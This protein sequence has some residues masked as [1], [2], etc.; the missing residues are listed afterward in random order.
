M[1]FEKKDQIQFKSFVLLICFEYFS[2]AVKNNKRALLKQTY[3]N[4]SALFFNLFQKC[5]EVIKNIQYIYIY[6]FENNIFCEI[7]VL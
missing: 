2:M 5:V 3:F 7:E 6:F 1:S 4:C